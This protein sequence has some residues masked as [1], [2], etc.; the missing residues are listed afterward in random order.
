MYFG[1]SRLGHGIAALIVKHDGGDELAEPCQ[2]SPR[3]RAA[4]QAQRRSLSTP[5][6]WLSR[7]RLFRGAEDSHAQYRSAGERRECDSPISTWPRRF[8]RHQDGTADRLLSESR[9]HPGS[10]GA[11]VERR[12][13]D[14]E[15]TLAEVFKQR[16]YATAIYGKWHL[17]HH[18]Q[19]LP[20]RHGFDD[21]FGLPYSN[22]MWPHPTPAATS[23]RCRSSKARASLHQPR[24]VAAH[25]LVHRARRPLHPPCTRHEPFFLYVPHSMPHVP[26]ACFGKSSAAKSD[27]AVRRRDP[28]RS[29]G[30]SAE[31]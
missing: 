5:T 26:L 19:F 13:S 11:E 17:G 9:R 14:R 8:A 6:T 1:L 22:D 24:P 30:R 15:Q 3:R 20:T 12:I 28:W 27:K 18:P 2:D 25:H 4:G 31:I 29:I 7:H 21:Y 16:G 23:R 10:A